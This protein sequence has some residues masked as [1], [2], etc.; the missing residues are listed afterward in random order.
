MV[1]TLTGGTV[2]GDD[3]LTEA[4]VYNRTLEG[5]T[6]VAELAP[7]EMRIH[8]YYSL[9]NNWSRLIVL[10]VIPFVMLIY[11][12]YKIYHDVQARKKRRFNN[13]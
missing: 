7:T 6:F 12:N 2:V 9:Y 5:K 13:R 3:Q 1:N 8:P 4:V 10:G 11:L